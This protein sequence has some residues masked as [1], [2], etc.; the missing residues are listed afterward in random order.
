LRRKATSQ[1]PSGRSFYDGFVRLIAR[2][3]PYHIAP[4]KT[5]IAFMGRVR[6]AGITA[7]AEAGMTC[8]FALPDPLPSP[9]FQRVQEVV[10][11]WWIHRL[12]MTDLAQ[13]D[14]ELRGWLRR[15]YLLI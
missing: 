5:R 14:R 3:G 12:R 7:L 9:R 15:S 1:R 13:L 10:P 11:G 2:C 8:A 6:F 4:A